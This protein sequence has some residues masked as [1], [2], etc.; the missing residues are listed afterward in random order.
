MNELRWNSLFYLGA[1]LSYPRLEVVVFAP[2]LVFATK[3]S[4]VSLIRSNAK[5]GY[6]IFCMDKESLTLLEDPNPGVMLP[7]AL[8]VSYRNKS[9]WFLLLY[10]ESLLSTLVSIFLEVDLNYEDEFPKASWKSDFLFLENNYV[11]SLSVLW[12][13]ILQDHSLSLASLATDIY[14]K[15]YYQKLFVKINILIVIKF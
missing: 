12:L 15:L 11:C 5:Y 13:N 9:V 4:F 1:D 6:K 3:P 14:I 2:R 7:L 10:W 8:A